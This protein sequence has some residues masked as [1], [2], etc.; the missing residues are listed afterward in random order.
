[1]NSRFKMAG[2]AVLVALFCMQASA[3]ILSGDAL[4]KVV[5]TTYFFAGQSAAVQTRNSVGLKSAGGHFN[6]GMHKHGGP[7]TG[8]H[9][10]GDLGNLEADAQGKATY[11]A[12]V[13]GISLDDPKTGIIGKSVIVHGKA[14]DLKS[15]PAGNA[16][17]RIGCGVIEK[18]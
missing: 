9:H 5:P 2:L 12:T 13:Q 14:D 16:G 10:A 3:Q 17:P 8:E 1:M 18:K 4:K 7:Q 15:Q 6:P 11:D